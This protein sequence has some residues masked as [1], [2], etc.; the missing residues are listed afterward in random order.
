MVTAVDALAHDSFIGPWPARLLHVACR[1]ALLLLFWAP[2][3]EEGLDVA[4]LA[5]ACCEEGDV[6]GGGTVFASARCESALEIVF[7]L[8]PVDG[9]GM[10]H[11]DQ[12]GRHR[13]GAVRMLVRM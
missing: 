3:L 12:G 6:P 1:R 10:A 7:R 4:A 5:L 13:V 2:A 8:Q 9:L 11:E